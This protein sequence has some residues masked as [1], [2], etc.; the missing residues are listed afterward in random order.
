MSATFHCTQTIHNVIKTK[1]WGRRDS[2]GNGDL[3]KSPPLFVE[4]PGIPVAEPLARWLLL[5][6]GLCFVGCRMAEQRGCLSRSWGP[7]TSP[8]MPTGNPRSTPEPA[9][10]QDAFVL[11]KLLTTCPEVKCTSSKLKKGQGA[12]KALLK[13]LETA[14]CRLEFPFLLLAQGVGL[15]PVGRGW[16]AARCG[17]AEWLPDLRAALF[18]LVLVSSS[19][20][21]CMQLL[22]WVVASV[23]IRNS[24]SAVFTSIAKTKKWVF[25]LQSF[26]SFI[27]RLNTEHPELQVAPTAWACSSGPPKSCRQKLETAHSQLNINSKIRGKNICRGWGNGSKEKD[28]SHTSQVP[29]RIFPLCSPGSAMASVPPKRK[30]NSRATRQGHHQQQA[31]SLSADRGKSC[32]LLF[33]H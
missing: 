17:C 10:S 9:P 2:C 13:Y 19:C 23:S 20:Q 22:S 16:K 32:A 30:R 14:E 28:P 4:P 15:A 29:T 8:S 5:G 18:T 11:P 12:I 7:T 26:L 1:T 6:A 24:S 31:R 33:N 3:P 25:K 27:P 21:P